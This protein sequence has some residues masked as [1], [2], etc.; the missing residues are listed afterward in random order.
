MP[1]P[2]IEEA[3]GKWKLRLGKGE[4][5]EK[6]DFDLSHF[7]IRTAGIGPTENGS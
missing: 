4:A 7:G 2:Q 1:S 3:C 6:V 5:S